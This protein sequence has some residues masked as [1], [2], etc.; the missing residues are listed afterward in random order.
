MFEL[1]GY[2]VVPKP[3]ILLLE[4]FKTIWRK[5]STRGKKKALDKFA[6][7]YFMC[8]P[9]SENPFA[10]WGEMKEKK[11]NEKLFDG[12]YKPCKLVKEAMEVYKETLEQGNI[13]MRL[14]RAN[15]NHVESIIKYLEQVDYTERTAS[16]AMVHN[17]SKNKD[18]AK[19]SAE[20][21]AGLQKLEQQVNQGNYKTEKLRG[22]MEEVSDFERG[23]PIK[24]V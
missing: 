5:D 7:I 11:I 21:L 12:K 4:P 14:Y 9:T 23:E 19:E 16:G 24:H 8:N 15:V 1:D 6:Y 18:Q 13:A 17:I 22:D 10:G 20:L 2:N 3:H